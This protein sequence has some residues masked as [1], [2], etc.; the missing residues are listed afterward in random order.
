MRKTK[1]RVDIIVTE[2]NE[3]G[4]KADIKTWI[5]TKITTGKIESATG[6][7]ETVETPE[8]FQLP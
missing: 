1:I 3:A 2:E 8:T 5:L 7:V 6:H 4:I